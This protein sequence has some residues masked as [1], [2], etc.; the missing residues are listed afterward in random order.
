LA[1]YPNLI[2]T[3][4]YG[5]KNSGTAENPEFEMKTNAFLNFEHNP[6]VIWGFVDVLGNRNTIYTQWNVLSYGYGGAGGDHMR[7]VNTLYDQIN[8]GDVRKSAFLDG[9]TRFENYR[10]ESETSPSEGTV[11]TYSSL[12]FAAS[13]GKNGTKANVDVSNNDVCYMRISEVLLM[14]AEAQAKSGDESGAKATLN[15]LL[16]ARSAGNATLTADNYGGGAS[17]V[18]DQVK[19][20]W[21]IEMWG[22]NAAEYFNNKRWGVNVVR[23]RTTTNHRVD[24]TI[25]VAN[26]T[27]AIPE[28]EL[29][30]NPYLR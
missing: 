8:A 9:N 26:M 21:R 10:Y 2:A 24:V 19:L 29:L 17:S 27:L 28:N 18:L 6:E 16:A 13:L 22:E 3:E 1:K 7:I 4:Y 14:K 20:Q 23:S 25:P 15:T 5:G 11:P 30:Y 12:K